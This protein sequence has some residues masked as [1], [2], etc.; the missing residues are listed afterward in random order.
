MSRLAYTAVE[1][2]Y[3]LQ[4]V[5]M[6]RYCLALFTIRVFFTLRSKV[7]WLRAIFGCA[8]T[9]P[10]LPLS[11]LRQSK[12]QNQ[13]FKAVSRFAKKFHQET[14]GVTTVEYA[15]LLMVIVVLCLNVIRF[16]GLDVRDFYNSAGDALDAASGN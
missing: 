12:M 8:E 5:L 11:F 4:S 15:I 14:D 16:I 7:S 2:V 13:F 10:V 6:E 1:N 3:M 9:N